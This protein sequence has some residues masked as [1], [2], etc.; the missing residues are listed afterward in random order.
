[1]AVKK[2][3]FDGRLLFRQDQSYLANQ[4]SLL[5]SGFGVKYLELAANE[6]IIYFAIVSIFT[7]ILFL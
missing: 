6:I 1:M 4:F 2:S 5:K 3:L 7:L